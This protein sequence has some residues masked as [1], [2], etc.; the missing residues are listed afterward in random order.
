MTHVIW[1]GYKHGSTA[2]MQH[3]FEGFKS[4]IARFEDLPPGNRFYTCTLRLEEI[5]HLTSLILTLNR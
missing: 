1:S 4:Q 5:D 3:G 2:L